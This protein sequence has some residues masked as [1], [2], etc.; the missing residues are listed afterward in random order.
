MVPLGAAFVY[1][2]IRHDLPF[3]DAAATATAGIVTLVPEGLD[4]AHEHD[5]RR[6]RG[7]AHPP[8]DARAV[9]QLGRVARKRRHGLPGQ[10]RHAHRRGAL[11]AQRDCPRRPGGTEVRALLDGFAQSVSPQQRHGRR[12]R[13]RR[14]HGPAWEPVQQVPFSSRWKWSAAAAGDRRGMAG[15]GRPR[16]ACDAAL[17]AAAAHE[18]EG[19]RVLAF[20]RADDRRRPRRGHRR[21]LSSEPLAMVVL[22]ERLRPDAI[23]T[24]AF[25]REQGVTIKVLSGDSP[26][27]V[28]AV[29]ARAGI[30]AGDG[31]IE[32]ADLP[33]DPEQL[34]PT[35]SPPAAS[36]RG[37][38][39]ST[40]GPWSRRL[41][42]PRRIRGDDRRRRERRA[43]DEGVTA[44]DRTGQRQPAGQERGRRR[45]RLRRASPRSRAPSA[46]A[47]RS[48]ETCSA[49]PSCS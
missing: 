5:L 48:S 38:P 12:D 17:G 1:V 14:S 43:R 33:A 11:A 47:A 31:A 34:W 21:H 32:G 8:R 4:P 44:C 22:E 46:R 23:D 25:L 27:T 20:G 41:T 19:R 10:D 40:S 15:A 18:A 24:V 30:D 39:L 36:S 9:P 35:W 49:S 3:R 6:R 13:G 37:S 45:A 7:A 26:V 29:A 42:G 16:R 2:L 28:A